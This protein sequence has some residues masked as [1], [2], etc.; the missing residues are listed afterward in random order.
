[1]L[2]DKKVLKK[3]N[4]RHNPRPTKGLFVEQTLR[5]R[6]PRVIGGVFPNLPKYGQKKKKNCVETEE[7]N[8]PVGVAC[9]TKRKDKIKGWRGRLACQNRCS[10]R[11]YEGRTRNITTAKERPLFACR[12]GDRD[13]S[14]AAGPSPRIGK[15]FWSELGGDL[16]G[17]VVC[18]GI[19]LEK[20]REDGVVG[21]KHG[22]N[23]GGGYKLD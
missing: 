14:L 13:I 12:G 17:S 19:G 1:M 9:P 8:F 21:K 4:I 10:L 2:G 3:I 11:K 23:G 6:G 5:R 22:V 16:S 20:G 7:K 15:K 18:L